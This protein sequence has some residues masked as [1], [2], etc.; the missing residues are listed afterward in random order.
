M[1]LRLPEEFRSQENQFREII[2][3]LLKRGKVET[4]LRFTPALG[5]VSEIKIN[6]PLAKALIEACKQQSFAP[7][8]ESLKALIFYVVAGWRKICSRIWTS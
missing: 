4:S 6:E 7:N 1:S 5:K 2:Q 3:T 8:T